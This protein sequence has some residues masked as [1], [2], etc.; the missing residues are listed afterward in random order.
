[1]IYGKIY[2]MK[3]A[4]R[5]D[6]I[7]P[8][9]NYDKFNKVKQI[10]DEVGIK[11]LIGVVP[12]SKD[13]TLRIEKPHEDFDKLVCDLQQNGW[14]IALHGYNHL[15]TT[16]DKGIFPI[17]EFSEFAGVDYDKQEVMIRQGLSQLREWG[18]EPTVFMA[19]G[20]TFDKNTL[21][22][23]KANGINAI[24]DGFGIKPYVREGVTFYPISRRR[25]ECISDK[26]GYSTYVLHTNTMSE[27]GIEAF[28]KMLN[29]NRDKFISFDEYLAV[30][31][32]TRNCIGNLKEYLMALVK[33]YLVSKKASK[34]TVIH[35]Q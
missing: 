31:P 17:N 30:L 29:E 11:P 15:Y 16:R 24:T 23:L 35:G 28:K 4:I 20:H 9:M 14:S 32:E 8:D 7:A 12:Y 1:M 19:P 25:S 2:A 5:L 34:G 3:T 22:A 26:K 21:K 33:H 27:D 6:D 18:L 13:E 10:L